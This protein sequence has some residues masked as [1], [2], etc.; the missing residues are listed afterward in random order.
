MHRG[1]DGAVRVFHASARAGAG[2]A[3]GRELA[4]RARF[5]KYRGQPRARI[6]H[7]LDTHRSE[8]LDADRCSVGRLQG[9]RRG[10][11]AGRPRLR[12]RLPHGRGRDRIVTFAN[13]AVA[14]ELVV[15]VDEAAAALGAM[16]ARCRL[17]ADY[18]PEACAGSAR[19]RFAT[20]KPS[21]AAGAPQ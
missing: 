4:A 10:A 7:R 2:A 16:W 17:A 11:Q 19:M 20:W 8:S 21:S 6:A 1:F 5:S 14:R 9:R 3:P 12:H 15:D 13:G 18:R